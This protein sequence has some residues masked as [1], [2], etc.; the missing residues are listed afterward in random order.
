MGLEVQMLPGHGP[1]FPAPLVTPD[2][3]SRLKDKTADIDKELKYVYEAITLTRH[4]LE[5]RCPLFGFAGAPWTLMAYMIEGNSS[6]STRRRS[7]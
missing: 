2:D 1:H 5:G 6:I 7:I 3:M 4:K